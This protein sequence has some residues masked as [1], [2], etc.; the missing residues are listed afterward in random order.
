MDFSDELGPAPTGR[1]QLAAELRRLRDLAG[2][3]GRDLAQR[4]GISQSKVSRIEAGAVVPSLPEVTA[5]G[6]ELGV[7]VETQKRLTAL[8]EAAYN[9]VHPWHSALEQPGVLQEGAEEH[10]SVATRLQVF[11]PS[12]V[13]GLL[14]TAE[15]ARR[16]ITLFHRQY[17]DN[18][19]RAEVA[20][21]VHRQ[22][23]LYDESRHFEFLIT[24]SAL[25]WRPGSAT[26]LL[27]QLDRIASLST[28]GNVRVGLIP[29][30][31]TATTLTTHGFDIYEGDGGE[32]DTSVLVE[33]IHGEMRTGA[34]K[35]VQIYRA[36]WNL[37]QQ[38]AIFD[39][40]ARKFLD[41]VASNLRAETNH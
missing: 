16:V 7:P 26:L 29:L 10:E 31:T 9:E 39:D 11:Q 24:E 6:K 17:T 20:K 32:R 38:M 25:R 41:S 2:V 3:S 28:L 40:E 33:M 13:P 19:L 8:T 35:H 15:Y 27:A 21:R 37:L 36:R 5:W 4:V 23:A 18:D 30:D 1:E 22:L 14:Q 34:A 12:V